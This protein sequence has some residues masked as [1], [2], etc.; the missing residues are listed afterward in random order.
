MAMN[1]LNGSFVGGG[2][3]DNARPPLVAAV[4]SLFPNDPKIQAL[5]ER[6]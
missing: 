5:T 1:F 2:D 6:R 3:F 4:R